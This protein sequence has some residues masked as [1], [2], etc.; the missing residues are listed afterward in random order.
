M[1]AKPAMI[2]AA[3]AT[4]AL[5]LPMIILHRTDILDFRIRVWK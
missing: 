1:I 4:L 2:A 5:M 3:L